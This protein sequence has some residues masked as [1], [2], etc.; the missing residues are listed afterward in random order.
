LPNPI[1]S[2]WAFFKG[3][4]LAAPFAFV[5]GQLLLPAFPGFLPFALFSVPVL[6]IAGLAM[7]DPRLAGTATPFAINFLVFLNPHQQMM[8]SPLAFLNGTASI[9]VGILLSI[10][11]F[12]VVLP[13]RPQETAARLIETLRGDLL[14]LCLHDRIPRP[15]AFESLAYD[16]VN[17]LIPLL[18][19]Q[20]EPGKALLDG[21]V[22]SA[23][24]GLE[25]L[26]L[27]RSEQSGLLPPGTVLE[28]NAG[29][30]R[31]ADLIQSRP[32]SLHAVRDTAAALQ[33]SAA[34][35]GVAGAPPPVLH[36]AASLR[37]I[38]AITQDHPIFFER[39]AGE[40]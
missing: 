19:R 24:L 4:L 34:Q 40:A 35:I 25:I 37:L 18:Q 30:R 10:A 2:A 11:V 29:L 23:M 16:R 15:S 31:F 39:R 26:R 32:R 7:A 13:Q 21:C 20:G 5:V 28:A 38:A 9:L 27:R 33:A 8:Y 36:A 6:V 3:T 1:Q 14:R 22:A 17:Q 12:A